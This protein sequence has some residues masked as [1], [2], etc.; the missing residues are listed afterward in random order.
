MTKEEEKYSSKGKLPNAELV[1]FDF[2]RNPNDLLSEK[3]E[4]KLF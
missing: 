4:I 1:K 3:K 2:S